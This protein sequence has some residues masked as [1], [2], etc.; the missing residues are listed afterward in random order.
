MLCAL[1]GIANQMQIDVTRVFQQELFASIDAFQ[2]TRVELPSQFQSAIL[3]SI[4]AK[5]NIS[6]RQRYKENMEVTF[7]TQILIA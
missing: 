3:A 5:Q 4:Q 6:E 2:I 7:S 1:A